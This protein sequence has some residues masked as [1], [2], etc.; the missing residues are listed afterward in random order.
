MALAFKPDIVNYDSAGANALLG[1]VSRRGEGFPAHGASVRGHSQSLTWGGQAREA[2]NNVFAGNDAY[3]KAAGGSAAQLAA[4][5]GPIL[6][7]RAQLKAVASNIIED[8]AQMRFTFSDA[9]EVNDYYGSTGLWHELP[10]DEKA[11]YLKL[12]DE[13][14]K[15]VADVLAQ[16][17]QL[18]DA[19]TTALTR[20]ANLAVPP[21]LGA[22]QTAVQSQGDGL[23]FTRDQG[24]AIFQTG[25][26]DDVVS[27]KQGTGGRL[28]VTVNGKSQTLSAQD[29]ENVLIQTQGGNDRVSVDPN[30][31]V[32]VRFQLGDGN[33]VIDD[34]AVGGSYIDAGNGDDTVTLGGGHNTVYLGAGNNTVTGSKGADYINGGSGNNKINAG[35]GNSVIYGGTGTNTINAGTGKNTIYAGSGQATINNQGG[36]DTVYAQAG[37]HVNEGSGHNQVVTIQPLE[38]P[39]NI[40]VQGSPEFQR[41]IQDD[42]EMLAAS[43]DGQKMLQGLGHSGHN[44]LIDDGHLLNDGKVLYNNGYTAPSHGD[45]PTNDSDFYYDTQHNRPGAGTDA[46][47][48]IDTTLTNLGNLTQGS[49]PDYHELNPTVVMYHEMAHAY[50]DT[51]GT[52]MPGDYG[53]NGKDPVDSQN[54]GSWS[55]QY[56]ANA[57]HEAVGLPVDWDGNPRTPE[58]PVPDSVHP[59]DLTEN[60]L[61]DEMGLPDRE[62]Y[63]G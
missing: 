43:P 28:I 24:M 61:R 34:Q 52:M 25:P 62:H 9:G 12:R 48:S 26:G 27:V 31:T 51:N 36:N 33:D 49:A 7:A 41:R 17:Q 42:L 60:A 40:T 4:D 6:N 55:P 54:I 3:A 23:A 13:L 14:P 56:L 53:P 46:I 19:A 63:L 1:G 30:V 21:A 58:A 50:D 11:K 37:T 32:R 38:V 16:G 10:A 22:D 29:S 5:L 15:R 18:D 44:L 35:S 47:I 57:E 45:Q 2:A 20:A 59:H 39:D 8:G